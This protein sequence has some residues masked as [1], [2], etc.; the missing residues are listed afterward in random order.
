MN[1][2]LRTT[3]PTLLILLAGLTT[4]CQDRSF[5]MGD[6]SG[7]DPTLIQAS[8]REGEILLPEDEVELTL[9]EDIEERSGTVPETLEIEILDPRG[10]SLGVRELQ[11]RELEEPLPSIDVEASGE[12]M[13]TLVLRLFSESG[14]AITEKRIR[15]F[16]GTRYPSIDLLETYPPEA[17]PPGGK[18][19]VVPKISADAGSWLR[20]SSGG[21]VLASGG[22]EEFRGGFVWSAPSDTGVYT[23]R[24]ELFPAPPPEFLNGGYPFSSPVSSEVQFFVSAGAPGIQRELGPAER[25]R[26]LL[27]LNGELGDDGYASAEFAFSSEAPPV[28]IRE[29]VF[30][31]RFRGGTQ[32]ESD[33]RLLPAG[34]EGGIAPFTLTFRY[35]PEGQQSDSR[36]VQVRDPAG[37]SYFLLGIDG[38]SRPHPYLTLHGVDGVLRPS[39]ALRREKTREIAVSLIPRQEQIEVRWYH[40]G[41]HLSTNTA[42]YDPVPLPSR[43]TTIIGGEDGFRG[44]LYELGLF[45]RDESGRPAADTEVFR[46]YMEDRYSDKELFFAEGYE[47]TVYLRQED[48]RQ[49]EVHADALPV[50]ADEERRLLSLEGSWNRLDVELTLDQVS[51]QG[52]EQGSNDGY[53]FFETSD[54]RRVTVG[55]DGSVQETDGGAKHELLMLRAEEGRML[56]TLKRRDGR[57]ILSGAGGVGEKEITLAGDAA[58]E[59]GIGRTGGSVAGDEKGLLRVESLLVL[60]GTDKLAEKEEKEEKSSDKIES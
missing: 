27:H 49:R 21:E 24:L 34:E 16:A 5:F 30:G 53:V 44:V 25:Y 35:L 55:F 22:Y 31:Y 52:S 40:N 12:G 3:L 15:F 56:V 38:G 51:E 39:T 26:H 23:L 60:R 48:G 11:G 45:A 9:A 1:R 19:I 7:S 36:L 37:S 18:G 29:G 42:P 32:L 17:V 58:P 59:L 57:F 6:Q 10:E 43:G 33:A 20:W 8:V 13:H 54:G 46:R 14:A 50:F 47:D 2:Y 28:V 41:R 4:A